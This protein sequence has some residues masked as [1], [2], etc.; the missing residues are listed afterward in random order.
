MPE[1]ILIAIPTETVNDETVR[2]VAWKFASGSLVQKDDLICEA[3]TSKALMEIHAPEAGTLIYSASVGDDVPVGATICEILPAG[4]AATPAAVNHPSSNGLT[5]DLPSPPGQ[6]VAGDASRHG[7][8]RLTPL[9]LKVATEFGID[10]AEFAPGTLVRRDDV[11]RKAGKL[12]PEKKIAPVPQQK[13]AGAASAPV[14]SGAVDWSDLPRRKI[15]EGGVLAAAQSEAVSSFV[16]AI[17]RAP[18]LRSRAD[19]LGFPAVGLNAL[20][21]FETGRLLRKYPVFNAVYGRQRIGIYRDVNIGWAIDEGG[22]LVVPVVRNADQKSLAEIGARM[23]EQLHGYVENTLATADVA[24]GTFTIT[25]LSGDGISFF[26]PL[27][28]QGQS[29]ILGIGSDRTAKEEAFFLT[30]AFNHRLTEGRAAARFLAEL[31]ERLEAHSMV[32]GESGGALAAD[33]VKSFCALC[34]RDSAQLAGIR[35]ILL[36]SEMPAG[37]VCSLCVAGWT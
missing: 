2:I 34:Q 9:A 22:R 18:G 10:I 13:A 27:I 29:A 23:Q 30:L 19:K 15:I 33:P 7:P 31:R 14:I 21:V 16:S 12:P 20:I 6:P 28:S 25:D 26:Q 8:A 36:K 37:F 1:S 11:L 17:C 4:F 32:E 3:E 35:A 24:G 5:A